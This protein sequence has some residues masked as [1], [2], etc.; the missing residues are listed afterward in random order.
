MAKGNKEFKALLSSISFTKAPRS[1]HEELS[2]L[3]WKQINLL[4]YYLHGH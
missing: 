2:K 4:Q 1:G 3:N